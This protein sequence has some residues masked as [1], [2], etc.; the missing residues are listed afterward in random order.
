[1]RASASNRRTG[2]NTALIVL[3]SGTRPERANA[4]SSRTTGTE[5]NPLNDAAV[6][7]VLHG[8]TRYRADQRRSYHGF[9]GDPLRISSVARLTTT[10][11][12]FKSPATST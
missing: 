3:H 4:S 9:R 10:S 2:L 1:M 12:A 8:A 11:P 7:P 6:A 5:A